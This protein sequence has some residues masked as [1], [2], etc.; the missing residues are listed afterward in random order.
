[1][2][3]SIDIVLKKVGEARNLLAQVV[4]A[5]SAKKVA[6]MAHAAEVY[7]KRQKLSQEAI[8]YAHE[9]KIEALRLL[10][11]YIKANPKAQ[12]TRGQMHGRDVSGGSVLVPPEKQQPP[13]LVDL[14]ISKRESA[15]S[16]RLAKMADEK[17][18]A[19]EALKKGIIT[20]LSGTATDAEYD[21]D[22][23]CTPAKYIRAAR[24]VMGGIDL[25]P[26]T[27]AAA[28]LYI[29]AKKKYTR[30]DSGLEHEWEG[31]IW[32]N[33]PY[34]YPLIEKFTAKFRAEDDAG[35]VEAGVILVNNCTD[36]E[37]FHLLL[38][39]YPVCFTRGRVAFEQHGKGFSTRQGQAFFCCGKAQIQANFA[40]IF[41][42]FGA[43]MKIVK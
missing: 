9:I 39:R 22:S 36:A 31:R 18:K 34:S 29:C 17:P 42:E 1:M 10:G 33:P 12:G 20:H 7:A 27:N 24:S 4:D 43:V 13:T 19:Y 5:G 14:G 37:W 30:D 16:Q 28:Q 40:K 35:N 15:Y 23:W 41:K 2:S 38:E 8:D 25:D 6:D 11:E 32:M 3:N 26:A 21:G